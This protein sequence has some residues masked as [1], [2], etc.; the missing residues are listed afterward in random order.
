[1]AAR[2][3]RTF[4]ASQG[5][6]YLCPLPQVPLGAGELEAALEAIWSG[7]QPLEPVFRKRDESKPAWIAEGCKYRVSMSVEAAGKL[8]GWTERRLVVRSLR[9][10]Q[11]A[12]MA[13]RSRITA[14][15]AAVEAFNQRGR[16]K[17][18][19]IYETLYWF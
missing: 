12:E 18:R 9:Q 11:A 19:S 10:T 3:T 4:I 1:M 17:I 14:A 13:L 16:G 7:A 6:F 5:D 2:A 15:M 8:Q